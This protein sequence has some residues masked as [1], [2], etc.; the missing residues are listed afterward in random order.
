MLPRDMTDFSQSVAAV[1]FFSSNFLFWYESGYFDTSS[2]L[3]PL[4]HTWSLA[5]EEQYYVV[6]PLL[7]MGFWWCTRRVL[8]LLLAVLALLSFGA[9]AWATDVMPSAAFY[10]LPF[11]AWELLSG[12]LAAF[13]LNGQREEP[14]LPKPISQFAGLAGLLMIVCAIVLFDE[15]TPFPGTAALLPVLGTTLIVLF[16]VPG[17]LTHQI[18]SFRPIVFIGLLSYS[19]Y[20]WHQPLLAYG[21][22]AYPGEFPLALAGCLGAM[23]LPLAYVTWRFVEQPFRQRGRIGQTR[24]FLVLGSSAVLL[25]GIG[26]AGHLDKGNLGRFSTNAIE[27][28]D[29]AGVDENDRRRKCRFKPGAEIILPRPECW[30]GEGGGDILVWGDSHNDTTALTLGED[31]ERRR[32]Y[33]AAY[34]GC[35]PIFDGVSLAFPTSEC[36]DFNQRALRFAEG[37]PFDA[38][39]LSANW[40]I[41]LEGDGYDNGEGGFPQRQSCDSTLPGSDRRG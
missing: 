36:I 20:L 25:F 15:S 2:E 9:S 40:R 23:S 10:L 33:H 11:R 28:A 7:M 30:Y 38:V 13:Y 14:V 21:R 16:S 8:M 17:T 31:L 4:L 39:V 24:I 34:A 22:L 32:V 3:K 19:M 18:L 27:I 12:A 5:V 1:I 26:L 29:A 41:Y 6:F 37:Q 35:P